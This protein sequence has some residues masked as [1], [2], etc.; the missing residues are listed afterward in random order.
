[1]AD[2]DDLDLHR[3][4]KRRRRA[5]TTT[6]IG[7]THASPRELG[8]MRKDDTSVSFLGSSS[9][10]HF[11]RTVYNAFARRFTDLRQAKDGGHETLVP[12][13]D[14]HIRRGKGQS[15]AHTP[16]WRK[17]E[18]DPTNR[19]VSFE[20]LVRLT[21]QYFEDWHPIYP[22]VNAPRILRVIEQISLRGIKSISRAD[23]IIVRSMIS[24][25]AIKNPLDSSGLTSA[26]A[27]PVELIYQT[28][29]EA[30]SNLWELQNEASSIALLQAAFSIQLFLT[31]ILHLNAASR[32]GG[33]VTRMTFH[34]GLHR[35]PTRYSCFT[36]EDVMMRRRI[37]WSIYCLERY[38]NQA[39]GVP[40]SIRDD[41]FDVCYPQAE[42]HSTGRE[43]TSGDAED[44]R[45]RLL[46]HLAK[47]ARLRGMISELRNKSIMHSRENLADAAE[48]DSVLLRWW[49]EV[50]D[51]VYPLEPES[52]SPLQP[53]QALLLIVSRHEAIISLYRP[54]LAAHNPVAADYKTAFQTCI[55]SARSLLVALYDYINSDSNMNRRRFAGTNSAQPRAPLTSPSF[56]STI[57]MSCMILIY[58]AWTG[59]FTNHGALRYARIGISVLRNLALRE[60]DWPQTCIDAI[61][62]LC[63]AMERNS[64]NGMASSARQ[65]TQLANTAPSQHNGTYLYTST[66]SIN[67]H[68][69]L[70]N[71][72]VSDRSQEQ[73]P[74]SNNRST[75]YRER[76]PPITDRRSRD[77]IDGYHF[78]QLR[79]NFT[80]TTYNSAA[81]VAGGNDI[82]NPASMVFGDLAGNGF[83]YGMGPE[84]ASTFS[85]LNGFSMNENWTVADGPWLIHGDFD[86]L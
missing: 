51:D 71:T 42:R 27:I 58:A 5:S 8:I 32:V 28:V 3:E 80:N 67:Q 29:H 11:V 4:L 60:R 26:A 61:E 85:N 69:Q 75:P 48:V 7:T 74:A 68:S 82:Y 22:F 64:Q 24:I 59:H 49:N 65:D 66:P 16:L 40:L 78:H 25:S 70:G 73:P 52:E 56:T 37:F 83:S 55:N 35:C 1:M 77:S 2:T 31:S 62:D 23:A 14:D 43:D 41:D 72:G 6:G 76:S 39:L 20:E 18:L 86:V 45:L 38:L 10:I 12:G 54:L 44:S 46:S 50:Y 30:M 9:G 53:Y 47:F 33:F 81:S 36:S 21:H 79:E 17:E 57:W 84:Y 63:F 13:E 15:K 34:L 19:T